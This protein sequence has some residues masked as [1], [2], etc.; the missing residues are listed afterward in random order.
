[1]KIT[2]GYTAEAH[3]DDVLIDMVGDAMDKFAHAATPGAFMVD[4]IPFRKHMYNQHFGLR[5]ISDWAIV[6]D[7][8]DWVPGTGF[9]KTAREW[10]AELTGVAEIPFNFVKHQMAQGK[11]E[12]SFLSRLIETEDS[13]PEV[14]D[15]NK[16]SSMSL[17]TAGADTVSTSFAYTY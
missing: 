6:K 9:K 17:Y 15:S 5:T 8:P 1:L 2:Y 14:V 7:L 4:M 13:D 11:H 16:W 12:T 3:K 10:E